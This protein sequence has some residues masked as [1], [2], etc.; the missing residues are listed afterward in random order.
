MALIDIA[1]NCPE[2][3]GGATTQAVDRRRRHLAQ[4]RPAADAAFEGVGDK[5]GRRGQGAEDF[6]AE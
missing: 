4:H 3:A 1:L 2:L 5:R 6:P